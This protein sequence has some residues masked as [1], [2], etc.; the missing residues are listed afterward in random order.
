M[1]RG[2]FPRREQEQVLALVEGSVVFLDPEN[3]G[4]VL[5]GQSFDKTAWRLANL[6][7]GSFEAE[8]LGPDDCGILGMSQETTCYV[9]QVYFDDVRLVGSLSGTWRCPDR[10]VESPEVVGIVLAAAESRNGWKVIRERCAR[11]RLH[12]R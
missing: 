6:F 10:S 2:L 7:L 12:P 4:D 11:A 9:S 8:L 3:I 5:T 1:V